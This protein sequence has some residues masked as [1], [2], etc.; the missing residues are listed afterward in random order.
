MYNDDITV[1]NIKYCDY[2]IL[3]FRPIIQKPNKIKAIIG[4]NI[5]F[6]CFSLGT[7]RWKFKNG[8]MGSNVVMSVKEKY[9]HQLKI[10]AVQKYNAGQYLCYSEHDNAIHI[11]VAKLTIT[12]E[13]AIFIS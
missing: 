13:T 3:A 7:V 8:P 12:G 6:H 4:D 11:D 9:F 5:E 1:I 10:N 2:H